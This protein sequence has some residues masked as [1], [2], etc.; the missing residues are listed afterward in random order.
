MN[1]RNNSSLNYNSVIRWSK[2]PEMNQR[3]NSSPNCNSVIRWSKSPEMNQRNNSSPNSTQWSVDQNTQR[4]IRGII[5]LQNTAQSVDWNPVIRWS[6]LYKMNSRNNSSLT[7]SVDQNQ[8]KLSPTP[9]ELPQTG[10]RH[11]DGRR[12][13]PKRWNYHK[14]VW[15]TLMVEE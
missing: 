3:N 8:L 7:W 11:L 15:D 6:N 13:N 9:W 2:F 12:R 1:Q 10:V 5:P 4:W 14:Q